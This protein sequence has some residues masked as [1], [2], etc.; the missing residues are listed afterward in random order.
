MFSE[1]G[2]TIKAASADGKA[3]AILSEAKEVR[4][5]SGR[6][7][8]MEQ[9]IRGDVTIIKA[10]KA[11]TVGNLVFRGTANNFSQPMATASRL[12]IAEVEEVVEAGELDP[13]SV[14]NKEKRLFVGECCSK[15]GNKKRFTCQAFMWI[16][17]CWERTTKRLMKTKV[18]LEI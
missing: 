8:V 1:G 16:I 3:P 18:A 17:W 14:R 6:K 7:Y 12:V 4:E 5:F 2:L 10:W 13:A 11:D 15:L 9:A